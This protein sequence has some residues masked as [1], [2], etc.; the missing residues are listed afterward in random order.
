MHYI[1]Y[2]FGGISNIA[3]FFTA[4]I[5][6]MGA[7]ALMVAN[8]ARYMQASKYGI[9]VKAVSQATISDSAAV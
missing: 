3:G 1:Q 8:L 2:I 7:V 5:T 9:P 4:S 6:I